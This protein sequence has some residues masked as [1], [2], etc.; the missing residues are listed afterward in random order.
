MQ[1]QGLGLS[2][3]H[4]LDQH[5]FY[6]GDVGFVSLNY[7]PIALW[8]QFCA[9]RELNNGPTVPRVGSPA[10]PLHL[11]HDFG[12][13]IPARRIGQGDDDWPW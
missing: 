8:L 1:R 4:R 6:Q 3:K 11:F 10:A 2:S 5:A 9:N 13:L 7:D 12:Q